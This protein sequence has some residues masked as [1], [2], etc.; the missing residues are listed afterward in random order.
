MTIRDTGIPE[1]DL[2]PN[3]A[4]TWLEPLQRRNPP[5]DIVAKT[6]LRGRS[7]EPPEPAWPRVFP[8]L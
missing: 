6:E 5:T 2:W 7:A 8:G 3:L 4:T 1:G